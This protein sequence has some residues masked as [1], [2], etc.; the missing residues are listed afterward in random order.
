M[1]PFQVHFERH[2]T[3]NRAFT[4]VEV[5]IVVAIL[6]LIASAIAIRFT[7]QERREIVVAAE[8]TADLLAMFAHRQSMGN[9]RIALGY[10]PAA[11][12]IMLLEQVGDP[13]NPDNPAR[14]E[15]GL[16]HLQVRLPQSISV[17]AAKQDGVDIMPMGDDW[18]IPAVPGAGR[19]NVELVLYSAAID[20][21]ATVYLPA[22]EMDA[23]IIGLGDESA[24]YRIPIDLDLEGRSRES[25]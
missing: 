19:P 8:D 17:I 10:D 1:P 7:G 15:M 24:A 25:W 9:D 20:Q 21:T 4:L 2:C 5:V 6:A 11:G 22:F 13:S 23:K 12:V 16:Q 18:F 14:W 3:T